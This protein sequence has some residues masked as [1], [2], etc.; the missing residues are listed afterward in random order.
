MIDTYPHALFQFLL[1]IFFYPYLS[2]TLLYITLATG[3][4]GHFLPRRRLFGS[5]RVSRFVKELQ[6]IVL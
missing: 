6:L 5:N 2:S 4:E 3:S 1:V